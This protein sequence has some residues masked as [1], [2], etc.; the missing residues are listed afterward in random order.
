MWQVEG[1]YICKGPPHLLKQSHAGLVEQAQSFLWPQTLSPPGT[2][3]WANPEVSSIPTLE[4]Q[5]RQIGRDH[6][7]QQGCRDAA[8]VLVPDSAGNEYDLSSLSRVRKPWTAVDTSR[9]SRRRT[10]YLSVCNPLPYIPG[11]HG[12]Y[13]PL[14]SPSPPVSPSP[15]CLHHEPP[16]AP[17]R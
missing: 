4:F 1:L 5:E 2:C 15:C 6:Q 8:S 9:D 16:L 13:A 14:S 12:S 3:P 11:C 10:F 17:L 7:G